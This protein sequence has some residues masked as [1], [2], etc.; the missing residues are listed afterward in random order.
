MKKRGVRWSMGTPDGPRSTIWRVWSQTNEHERAKTRNRVTKPNDRA[1][2]SKNESV[3]EVVDLFVRREDAER[4]LAEA[5][6][7]EPTWKRE[8]RVVAIEEASG[9]EAG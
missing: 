1:R 2:T 4:A 7:D 5:L 8:L 6:A 3:S 9:E